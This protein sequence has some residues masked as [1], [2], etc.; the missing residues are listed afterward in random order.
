MYSCAM[1]SKNS[2]ACSEI[3][4]LR[5]EHCPMNLV[6]FK[7]HLYEFQNKSKSCTILIEKDTEGARNILNFLIFKN[8]VVKTENENGVLK[9]FLEK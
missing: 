6:K 1:D 3:I 5:N 2:Q 7:F 9:L 4:D 8:I